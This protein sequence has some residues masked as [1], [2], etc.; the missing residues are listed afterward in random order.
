[1]AVGR[2]LIQRIKPQSTNIQRFSY[3][4]IL[5]PVTKRNQRKKK[6]AKM[7]EKHT[8]RER[9]EWLGGSTRKK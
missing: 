9:E 5:F 2:R 1:M 3:C 7:T 8:E 6:K 4:S